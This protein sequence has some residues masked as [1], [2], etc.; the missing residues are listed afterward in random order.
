[1]LLAQAF[2]YSMYKNERLDLNILTGIIVIVIKVLDTLVLF[3]RKQ[4]K[5]RGIAYQAMNFVISF[6]FIIGI[7]PLVQNLVY[8]E[9]LEVTFAMYMMLAFLT[10]SFQ[11]KSYAILIILLSI[12]FTVHNMFE[13][14]EKIIN[15]QNYIIES[16]MNFIFVTFLL[17]VIY[18]REM[19]SRKAYNSERIVEVEIR[20]TEELLNKLVPENALAAIKNDQKVIDM[21]DNV[22]V[23]YSNLE[24]FLDYYKALGKPI[25][26]MALLNRI[27]TKFDILCEQ[28]GV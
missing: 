3:M 1:M 4:K 17:T 20:R 8:R 7:G 6:G 28:S 22:S 15:M 24:G 21:L 11:F 25:E 23:L 14:E 10:R 13:V 12:A 26:V 16:L 9:S 19:R 5:P 2:V 18:N 27:F